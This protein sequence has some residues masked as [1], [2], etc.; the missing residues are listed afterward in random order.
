MTSC[1]GVFGSPRESVFLRSVE[2]SKRVVMGFWRAPKVTRDSLVNKGK[3]FQWRR[4]KIASG[5]IETVLILKPRLV[6]R[7]SRY[8]TMVILFKLL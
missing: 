2:F 3:E 4:W 6:L 1:K 7:L 5:H 8:E